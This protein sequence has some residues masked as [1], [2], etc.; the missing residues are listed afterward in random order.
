TVATA[1]VDGGFVAT[2]AAAI[3]SAGRQMIAFGQMIAGWIA[4]AARA[5]VSA[6]V[7]VAQWIL[8]GAQA[9]LQAARMAAA[10]LI[11]MGPVGLV[12][13]AVIAVAVLIFKYWDQ[14]KAA[15]IKTWN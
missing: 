5:V 4:S 9:M 10:W 11:A 6:A 2:Q 12:I 13:A 7:V 3:V 8:M 1:R 14:I 15:T